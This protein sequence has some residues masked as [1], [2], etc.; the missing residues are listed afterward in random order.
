VHPALRFI[1]AV[2]IAIT[3]VVA[4]GPAPDIEPGV[5]DILSRDLRF[6][7]ADLAELA[8]GRI[9]K[10]TLDAAAPGEI[11]VV[12][13]ARVNALE[14]AFVDR[15]RDV[16]RFKTGPDMLQIGRFSN[17]PVLE[18]LAPLTID[19]TDVDL[20]GCRVGDCDI[21][22]PADV[23]ARFQ[24]EI[25]WRAHDADAR[26]AALFKKV[27]LDNVL[28]YVSGSPSRRITE[29]DDG[30]QPI[31]PVEDFAALL[32]NSPYIGALVPGLPD[33][34]LSF[35]SPPVVAGAQDL[36]YWSKEKFG[37]TPFIT[38]THWTIVPATAR[39]YVITSKDVYSSRYFDA[40]LALTI[41]SG[42][43][44]THRPFYL[45]YANRSRASALKGMLSKVRR[46]IVERRAK[47]S[48]EENLKTT[49]E[50]L[51]KGPDAAGG[52]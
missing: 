23:I 13:A 47:N 8:R 32:K 3:C 26:A 25:D 30:K 16:V 22:L 52:R 43:A 34:L 31:R 27:L 1:P 19:K 45:V 17:P 40:S 46:S 38:V 2:P 6:S 41:A 24:R 4:A 18:D 36:L 29:Y 42:A 21:R 10:H 14:E 37:L 39:T 49:K 48:L 50:R 12:G 9:V 35:P 11:A 15:V 44:G 5:L 28:A 51:E 20:R 7:T 33:H